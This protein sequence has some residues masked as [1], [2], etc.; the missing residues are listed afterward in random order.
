MLATS[1]EDG[2]VKFWQLQFDS[3]DVPLCLHEWQPHGGQP[4]S[5]LMFCD[6]HLVQDDK[7][8]MCKSLVIKAHTTLPLHVLSFLSELINIE[9]FL[10]LMELCERFCYV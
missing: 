2:G 5:K 1:S 6:N 9:L 8:V 3:D 10:I 7:Y 4:V